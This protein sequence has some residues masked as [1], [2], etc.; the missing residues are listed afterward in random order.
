KRQRVMARAPRMPAMMPSGYGR[1]ASA[2]TVVGTPVV[3]WVRTAMRELLSR[4]EGKAYQRLA[5]LP[6]PVEFTVPGHWPS[7]GSW[8]CRAGLGKCNND[9]NRRTIGRRRGY[10][11]PQRIDDDSSSTSPAL[12]NGRATEA[13]DAQ[14]VSG[15]D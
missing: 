11:T 13:A 5:V 7:R 6:P 10:R 8:R 12:S 14:G 1:A 2:A 3:R 9:D 15:G 4:C